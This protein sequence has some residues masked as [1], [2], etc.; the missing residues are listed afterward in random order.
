[1]GRTAA[2]VHHASKSG[3]RAT[4]SPGKNSTGQPVPNCLAISRKLAVVSNCPAVPTKNSF[5]LN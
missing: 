4:T 1:M 3:V 5:S 2:G